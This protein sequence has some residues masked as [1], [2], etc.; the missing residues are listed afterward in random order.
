MYDIR[1][2]NGRHV[3]P[4]GGGLVVFAATCVPREHSRSPSLPIA[5]VPYELRLDVH[6]SLTS[7]RGVAR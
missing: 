6:S 1:L 5:Y 4:M 7:P 2:T 3:K